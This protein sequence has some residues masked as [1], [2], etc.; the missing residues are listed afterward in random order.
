MFGKVTKNLGSISEKFKFRKKGENKEL[1]LTSEKNPNVLYWTIL[2]EV[3][4][5]RSKFLT[6][7]L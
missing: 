6:H 7:A 1:A 4:T 2:R 5:R 3:C